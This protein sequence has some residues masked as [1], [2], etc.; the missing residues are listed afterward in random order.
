MNNVVFWT[1]ESASVE[2]VPCSALGRPET[3][4][5]VSV[6]RPPLAPSTHPPTNPPTNSTPLPPTPLIPPQQTRS[7]FR[8]AKERDLDLDFHTDENGN[9]L[10]RGLRYVAQKAEQWGYQGRVVC[11]HCW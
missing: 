4:V 3:T 8:L 7:I 11:G 5:P 2:S 10:A 6:H 9:E 1:F